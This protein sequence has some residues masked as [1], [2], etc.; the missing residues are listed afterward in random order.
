MTSSGINQSPSR[1]WLDSLFK[2][3]SY[4][5]LSAR[6]LLTRTHFIRLPSRGI[7]KASLLT[8]GDV[9]CSRASTPTNLSCNMA[10]HRFFSL[11]MVYVLCLI[12]CARS[13]DLSEFYPFG[14]KIGDAQLRL[15][16]H[17]LVNLSTVIMFNGESHNDLYVSI[18]WCSSFTLNNIYRK[19]TRSMHIM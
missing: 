4:C 15:W 8:R 2:Q 10:S 12:D 14:K 6:I 7:G 3:E 9:R 18:V 5:M 11:R 16:S 1:S 19:A 13:L 17:K